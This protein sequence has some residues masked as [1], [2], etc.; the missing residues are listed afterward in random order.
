MKIII[1]ASEIERLWHVIED[2]TNNYK[3]LEESS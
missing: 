1:Y 3:G 2:L